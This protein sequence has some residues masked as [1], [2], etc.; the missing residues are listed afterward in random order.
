MECILC[1][2]QYVG[3]AETNF[4]IRLN[5]HQKGVQK[6]DAIMACKHFEQE[7]HNFNKHAKFT[8]IYQSTNTSK[9]KET[10]PATYQ[11]GKFFNFKIR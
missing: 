3:K 11:K 5:N 9:S 4:N 2:K 8:I 10:H 6:N 1:N 7:S